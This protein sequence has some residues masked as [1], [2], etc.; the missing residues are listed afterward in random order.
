MTK[1]DD[2][3]KIVATFAPSVNKCLSLS[4][5]KTGH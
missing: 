1:E 5:E 4:V 3:P 2:T